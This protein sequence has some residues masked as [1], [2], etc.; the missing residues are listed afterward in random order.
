MPRVEY[1]WCL[2]H[3]RVETGD[4]VCPARDRI[5][6][7]ATAAEAERALETVQQ[8]N[9]VWDAENARWER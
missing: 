5:G 9:E 7:F 6:P 1:Y 8:R 2:K 4:D 3:G